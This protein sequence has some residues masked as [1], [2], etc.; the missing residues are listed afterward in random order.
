MSLATSFGAVADAYNRGRPKHTPEVMEYVLSLIGCHGPVLDVGCGTGIATRQ[1]AERISP[2]YG[3]DIDERMIRVARKEHPS[4]LY[5][6][7]PADLYQIA[8]ADSLPF[9]SNMF[10]GVTAFSSFHW[11]C[12]SDSAKEI[13][14]VIQPGGL[15]IVVSGGNRGKEEDTLDYESVIAKV[16]GYPLSY[17]ATRK[18]RRMHYNPLEILTEAGFSAVSQQE[19]NI[20]QTVSIEDESSHVMLRSN[21]LTCPESKRPEILHEIK[22]CFREKYPSGFINKTLTPLVVSGRK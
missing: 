21:T 3:C 10:V 9:G 17:E 13:K 20:P 14:R 19:F 1:L 22:L 18:Y 5:Q 7:T 12:N 8:P 2:V 11:F 15:F 6:I 4:S 16:L